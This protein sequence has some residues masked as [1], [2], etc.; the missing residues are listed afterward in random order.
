MAF[1]PLATSKKFPFK[2]HE[3]LQYAER[4]RL[5]DIV[6]WLPGGKGFRVHNHELF[7]K[8]VLKAI[9]NHSNYKSFE[10]QLNNWGFQREATCTGKSYSNPN[11]VRGR[12][13]LCQAMT[14]KST[15][16]TNKQSDAMSK[17]PTTNTAGAAG[18]SWTLNTPSL[19]GANL[20]LVQTLMAAQT[21]ASVQPT[22]STVSS[23]SHLPEQTSLLEARALLASVA[24]SPTGGIGLTN[25]SVS[26]T[27]SVLLRAIRE[28]QAATT[29]GQTTQD[30]QKRTL[31]EAWIAASAHTPPALSAAEIELVLR[32]RRLR[33]QYQAL[34]D[35]LGVQ[36]DEM[37]L[38][39]LLETQKRKA[40]LMLRLARVAEQEEQHERATALLSLKNSPTPSTPS[41][42]LHL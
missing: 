20:E 7:C 29:L 5:E 30:F 31:L 23:A 13:S 21:K 37:T 36:H 16:T 18:L 32:Q 4:Q 8:K 28:H 9:F 35:Q 26:K 12:K 17:N 42:S 15:R 6:S 33:L 34:L 1:L 40:A 27:S 24:A 2:C 41:S 3:M 11:F 22:V 39:A 19:A 14:S 25:D 38:Q 10:K